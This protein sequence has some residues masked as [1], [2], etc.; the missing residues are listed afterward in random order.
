VLVHDLAAL[1]ILV[2]EVDDG[3]LEPGDEVEELGLDDLRRVR[4]TSLY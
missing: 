2:E 3:E 1:E 4:I